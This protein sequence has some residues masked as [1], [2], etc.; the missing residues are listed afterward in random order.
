MPRLNSLP[1]RLISLHNQALVFIVRG[2]GTKFRFEDEKS[3][4]KIGGGVYHNG[5]NSGTGPVNAS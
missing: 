1:L 5:G 3:T 4:E 2:P